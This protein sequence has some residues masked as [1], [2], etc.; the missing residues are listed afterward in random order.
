MTHKNIL[1]E[2]FDLAVARLQPVRVGGNLRMPTKVKDVKPVYPVAA[3]T[4]RVQGVVI[5]ETLIDEAGNVANARV[6]RSIP[7]LDDAALES[8]SKWQFS[9]TEINGRPVAVLVTI[10]VNFTLME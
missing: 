1:L 8:V 4:A 9:P 5:V 3:Q 7:P 6:L 2:A 10:T